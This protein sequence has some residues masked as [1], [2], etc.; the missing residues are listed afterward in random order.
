MVAAPE[1]QCGFDV[2]HL[3]QSAAESDCVVC[4]LFQIYWQIIADSVNSMKFNA[5][6]KKQG[7]IV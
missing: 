5:N 2:I 7:T 3:S 4:S 1:W 6:K